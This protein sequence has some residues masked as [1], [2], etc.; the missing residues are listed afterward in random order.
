MPYVDIIKKLK[1]CSVECETKEMEKNLVEIFNKDYEKYDAG[2]AINFLIDSDNYEVYMFV[3][4]GN[5]LV[6]GNIMCK[7]FKSKTDAIN[8]YNELV[9]II[10]LDDLNA[11][12]DRVLQEKN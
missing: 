3:G 4:A 2:C 8:Y 1:D 6:A 7:F 5:D 9:N 11:I 10:E 12:F